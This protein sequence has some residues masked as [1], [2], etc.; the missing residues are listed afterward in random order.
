MHYVSQPLSLRLGN[1]T[2]E[3]LGRRAADVQLPP[4]TLA[5]RYVEEGLRMDEHP[6]VRFADGPAGRRARLVGTGSDVWEVIATVTDNDGDVAATAEYL[7]MALGLVQAAVTYYGAFQPE[8][9][10]RIER[11]ERAAAEAHAAWRAG[12]AALQ[13]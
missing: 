11:N 13:R 8:I 1:T 5:Q 9:D 4:R 2:V 6:L 3:R 12:Q 7:G 10:E